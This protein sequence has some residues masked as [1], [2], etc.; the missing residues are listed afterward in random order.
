MAGWCGW[1]CDAFCLEHRAFDAAAY[2]LA[3]VERTGAEAM[4][5]YRETQVRKIPIQVGVY[6]LCDVD[7]VPIYVGQSRDGIRNRVRRHLTSARSDVIANRQ[8]DV[9]EIA[10]VW[11]YPVAAAHI[12][13]LEACLF[14]EFD[15]LSKL[16]NGSVPER[17]SQIDFDF[18]E[19]HVV[20][21][22]ADEDIALRRQPVYRLPRQAQQYERL[23]DHILNVKDSVDLRRSLEAHHERLTRYHEQFLRPPG[24]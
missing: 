9:W 17:P 20:Q 5:D 12:K 21:V 1:G 16:M 6:A 22:L 13:T 23:V 11:A 2:A 18:P 19:R 3:E 14:H 7:E 8:I 15:G 10:Y 4:P 24:A